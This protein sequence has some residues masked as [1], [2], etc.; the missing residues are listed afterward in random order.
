[1]QQVP[2]P[3]PRLRRSESTPD[4]C[5]LQ[6][7]MSPLL[8]RASRSSS[9]S[10]TPAPVR[11][12]SA[13]PV[14]GEISVNELM[15]EIIAS[16]S[17]HSHKNTVVNKVRK[18]SEHSHKNNAVNKV[19]K[20]LMFDD[21]PVR[22]QVYNDGEVEFDITCVDRG[23]APSL[24]QVFPDTDS[25]NEELVQ[26]EANVLSEDWRFS[27]EV[28]STR[29]VPQVPFS[30]SRVLSPEVIRLKRRTKH[31]ITSYEMDIITENQQNRLQNVTVSTSANAGGNA[32]T[33]TN[34]SGVAASASPP[35]PL[36]SRSNQSPLISKKH[37]LPTPPNPIPPPPTRPSS[38]SSTSS[39]EIVDCQP[40][41]KVPAYLKCSRCR[42]TRIS[43]DLLPFIPDLSTV[44]RPTESGFTIWLP[45][46]APPELWAL[47]TSM[48]M[49]SSTGVNPLSFYNVK[50]SQAK[51]M[52]VIAHTGER[53]LRV[54]VIE[55]EQV[56][57]LLLANF[58]VYRLYYDQ[59]FLVMTGTDYNYF[60]TRARITSTTTNNV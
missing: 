19:H 29:A 18:S 36:H 40:P 21:S 15:T 55:P 49:I 2:K 13:T 24:L 45:L 28:S 39:V 43:K 53:T 33:S 51:P 7:V 59:Y 58:T 4:L 34:T 37:K 56:K 17:E 3:S 22:T 1:M 30:M 57:S 44:L 16:D 26:I 48:S 5:R 9:R 38:R 25:E 52:K 35:L 47:A 54:F 42:P 50:L 31:G 10:S 12:R 20:S 14:R 41:P 6:K 8:S 27:E 23:G 32:S 60:V 11:P 46:H